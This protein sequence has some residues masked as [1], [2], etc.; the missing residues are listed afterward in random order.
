MRMGIL[1]QDVIKLLCGLFRNRNIPS[2]SVILD[3]TAKVHLHT[4]KIQLGQLR[5]QQLQMLIILIPVKPA[6]PFAAS[7]HVN[8]NPIIPEVIGKT[9]LLKSQLLG[10]LQIMPR[11]AVSFAQMDKLVCI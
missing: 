8:L 7:I 5:S 1:H 9:D 2:L 3:L 4:A 10:L 6:A 11:L